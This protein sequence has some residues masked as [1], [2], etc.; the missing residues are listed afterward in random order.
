MKKISIIVPVFYEAESISLLY[1]ELVK[2]EE[3]LYE[4]EMEMELIFVSE[5]LM[6]SISDQKLL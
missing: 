6:N 4:R 3:Q 5:F 2:V 1:K